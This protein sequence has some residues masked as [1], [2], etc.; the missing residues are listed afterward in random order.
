MHRV[1][2]EGDS[3]LRAIDIDPENDIEWAMNRLKLIATT[4]ESSYEQCF[5]CQAIIECVRLIAG[6]KDDD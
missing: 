3:S 5:A 1:D 4:A 2:I 6:C